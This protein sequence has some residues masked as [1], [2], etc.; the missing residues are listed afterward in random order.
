VI[1][2]AEDGEATTRGGLLVD[3]SLEDRHLLREGLAITARIVQR[4][5]W[6]TGFQMN[7]E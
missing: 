1:E 2:V 3:P 5:S 7:R 4:P 6:A